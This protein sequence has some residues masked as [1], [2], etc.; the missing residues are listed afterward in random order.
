MHLSVIKNS[1][2]ATKHTIVTIAMDRRA[3][4]SPLKS[5]HFNRLLSP[6]SVGWSQLRTDPSTVKFD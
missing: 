4:K 5:F 1:I 6:V 3:N 2:S